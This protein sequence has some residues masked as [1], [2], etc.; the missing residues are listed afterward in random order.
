[1]K[2]SFPMTEGAQTV[3]RATVAGDPDATPDPFKS[4]VANAAARTFAIGK[5]VDSADDSARLMIVTQYAG[6]KMVKVFAIADSPTAVTASSANGGRIQVAGADTADDATDDEFSALRSR[7]MYY[8]A[9]GGTAETLETA[10]STDADNSG[11]IEAGEL[12]GDTVAATA[13]GREV[14]SYVSEAGTDTIFGTS[15]DV[16]A[17]V[18]LDSTS[19]NSA[20]VTTYS[21]HPV[22]IHID[23]D[24]DG[25]TNTAAVPSEVTAMIP[26]ASDYDHI[27]FGVWAS[28]GAAAKSGAQSIADLGIGFVQNYSGSGMTGSDMPNNGTGAYSGNWVATVQAADVEGDGSIALKHGAAS[29]AANFGKGTIT[30]T[31][32]D[33]ATLSG[34]ISGNAFSG[35][36]A[37]GIGD[38]TLDSSADFEGS[39]SG[40]FYGAKAAEAAGVFT[41]ATEDNEGGAFNGAFGAAR[42]DN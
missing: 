27:H 2:S 38:P 4:P 1:M 17:Y 8:P 28:L 40:G 42:T 22:D 41:F 11:V 20:G 31:L 19:T 12:Q 16:M 34:D 6:T 37:S 36:K 25:D 32:T 15:D 3:G 24:P 5:T 10:D 18:V 9:A 23:T 39:F 7:G 21:Y 30:A 26:S 14:F 29:L 35:D 13:K 33:L